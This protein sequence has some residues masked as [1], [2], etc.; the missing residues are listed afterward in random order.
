VLRIVEDLLP[1]FT[2]LSLDDVIKV[3]LEFR[4]IFSK[5]INSTEVSLQLKLNT[6]GIIHR[7][8]SLGHVGSIVDVRSGLNVVDDCLVLTLSQSNGGEFVT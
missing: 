5:L 8:V 6:S 7:L 3:I 2:D 4:A 1:I